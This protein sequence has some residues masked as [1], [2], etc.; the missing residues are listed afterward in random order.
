MSFK[1]NDKVTVVDSGRQYSTYDKWVKIYASQWMDQWM[2]C[3][4]CIDTTEEYTVVAKGKHK[5]C[6][7]MLYLIQ[8]DDKVYIIG[9]QGIKA[10]ETLGF[11]VGDEVVFSKD[12]NADRWWSRAKI[13]AKGTVHHLHDPNG[14]NTGGYKVPMVG[15]DFNGDVMDYEPRELELVIEPMTYKEAPT[16]HIE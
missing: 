14:T 15:V 2:D 12:Y 9:E 16:A 4:K 8:C 10:V 6:N 5:D 1:V 3:D 7:K 11:K 13:G